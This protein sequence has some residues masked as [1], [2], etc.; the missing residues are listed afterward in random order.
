MFSE[1]IERCDEC[2]IRTGVDCLWVTSAKLSAY[3]CTGSTPQTSAD[4]AKAVRDASGGRD[5]SGGLI[6]F[7]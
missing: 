1:G 6:N 2:H 7:H 4:F 5:K 3:G